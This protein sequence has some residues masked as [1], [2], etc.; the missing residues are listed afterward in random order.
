MLKQLSRLEK[1]RNFLIVGFVIVMAISLVMFYKPGNSGLNVEPGKNTTTLAKVRSSEI[2]VADLAV[3][4]A[5]IQERFGGQVSL[6]Q[7]GLSDKSL[8]DQLIAEHVAAQEAERLGLGVGD[9]ELEE[10]LSKELSDPTGRFLFVDGSG[11]RDITK[12]QDTI[13]TRYGSVERYEEGRR[14][15]FEAKKLRTFVAA[16]VTISPEE[17]QNDYKRKNTSFDL[18]YA[19]VSADKLAEKITPTDQDL[20]GYYEQHKTDYRYDL[21]QKKIRY[22][23]LNQEKAGQKLEIPDKELHDRYDKLDPEHKQAGVKVQQILLRVR[24]K[25]LDAQVEAQAKD[26]VAKARAATGAAAETTFS[27]LAKGNSEDTATQK[28]GGLLGRVVKKN[29]NKVDALYDR[30]VDMQPGEIT[31]PIRYGG[32]WYILRRGESVPKTFE[33]AKAELLV[34]ARNQKAYSVMFALAGR[35][36]DALKQSHDAQKVAQQFAAEANMS[37]ADMVRET[38]YIKPGDDVKDIGSNQQFESAIANLNNPNDVGEPTG[39]KEGVA[40]PMFVD[41][42]EPRIPD[43][44]EV[45]DKLTGAFKQQRAKEQLDQKAKDLAASATSAADLKTA[46]EKAGL[47]VSTTEDSFKLGGSLGKAGAGAALDEAIYGLK[48][49]EVS[50]TPIKVGENF[51]VVGVTKRKEA[52]LAEFAKQ[53][54]QLTETM[55]RSRQ[56]QVYEDYVAAAIERMKK[57]GKVKI[58]KEVLDKLADDEEP[59]APQPRRPRLPFPTR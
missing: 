18:T 49:G 29:P 47:E 30:T 59:A 38:G 27:D 1:T 51:V 56:D 46:I 34:S 15:A 7:L 19:I 45:K 42:K 40:I 50:K 43:F 9:R 2:T 24:L 11:K 52:D 55:L 44:D 21:P 23:Y 33:E 12:Y 37:P 14:R 31:D 36:K 39:V 58:Y 5:G 57:E 25:E 10:E 17:V 13:S 26:L 3:Q 53:R 35:A 6:A 48:E 4:K 20:R 22:L 8:L 54:D 41:K 16:S 32:N 28:N